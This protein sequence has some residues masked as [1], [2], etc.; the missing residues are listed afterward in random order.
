MFWWC[1]NSVLTWLVAADSWF[2]RRTQT[3]LMKLPCFWGAANTWCPVLSLIWLHS[4]RFVIGS[5]CDSCNSALIGWLWWMTTWPPWW[6]D[7][8]VLRLW[9]LRKVLSCRKLEFPV[10]WPTL[11]TTSDD[12]CGSGGVDQSDWFRLNQVHLSTCPSSIVTHLL[13]LRLTFDLWVHVMRSGCGCVCVGGAAAQQETI[14]AQDHR[15]LFSFIQRNV[16]LCRQHQ[17]FFLSLN[18]VSRLC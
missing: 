6:R 13:L 8:R 16:F 12:R 9:N 18:F 17:S 2:F 3:L 15:V 11:N 1:H 10:L 7:V 4:S 14:G 5:R